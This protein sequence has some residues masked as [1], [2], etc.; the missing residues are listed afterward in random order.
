MMTGEKDGSAHSEIQA[1]FHYARQEA[2]EILRSGTGIA[3][4]A[5]DT[6]SVGREI[7]ARLSPHHPIVGINS[8]RHPERVKQ[9]LQSAYE[10]QGRY[11][12]LTVDFRNPDQLE[13]RLASGEIP[14]NGANIDWVLFTSGDNYSGVAGHHPSRAFE[15]A[16][17]VHALSPFLI[18]QRLVEDWKG[19]NTKDRNNPGRHHRGIAL[20]SSVA[21]T[22]G[23]PAEAPYVMAKAAAE[24]SMLTFHREGQPYGISA[25]VIRPGLI[26]DSEM[27]QQTVLLRPDVLERIPG[28]PT[29][30]GQV[31]ALTVM[32][33]QLSS[34]SGHV[35]NIDA[36]RTTSI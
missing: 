22:G 35:Y 23:S 12:C 10:T 14:L 13:Q 21:R 27:G 15:E 5:G 19:I 18:A 33:M 20:I 24:A 11:G 32:V 7:V 17:N 1:I 36:G 25:V 9:L 16:Y 31:A 3:L 2:I 30:T 6:G 29:T 26:V 34:A 4:V 28:D 8:G